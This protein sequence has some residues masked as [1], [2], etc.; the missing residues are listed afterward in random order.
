MR[1]DDRARLIDRLAES[2]TGEP[3]INDT[4]D[5]NTTVV[6]PLPG[7][8]LLD[9]LTG[10]GCGRCANACVAST[11]LPYQGGEDGVGIQGEGTAHN[12]MGSGGMAARQ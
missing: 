3:A 10:A 12:A 8:F 11:G 1:R 5:R 9:E 4:G 2:R 7:S 6:C